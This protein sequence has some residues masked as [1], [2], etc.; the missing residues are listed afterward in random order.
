M[1]TDIHS[2]VIPGVDDG[3]KTIDEA[4]AL[5]ELSASQGCGRIVATPHFYASRHDLEG[6]LKLVERQFNLL[7]DALNERKSGVELLLGFEVRYFS[8]ISKCDSLNRLCIS[9]T[10]MLLLE[11]GYEAVSDEILKEIMELYYQGYEV[12]LAHLERYANVRGFNRLKP[13][14]K[15]RYV[16]AQVNASS[17]LERQFSRT[18][19]KLLKA[20]MTDYIAGDMHSLDIRPPRVKEALE[21][22]E[23]KA[24]ASYRR[25]LVLN[26]NKH[27][28][29]NEDS[30]C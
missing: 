17:F 19:F 23:K 22:I 26:S 16:S 1:Y 5:I 9:K 2:H 29:T 18:A 15:N 12:V 6:R 27:F 3:A 24:G 25:H 14:V 10:N 7:C 30:L 8:G 21:L 11:L 28:E 20:G 4:V 13:L